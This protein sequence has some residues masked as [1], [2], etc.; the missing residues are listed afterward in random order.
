MTLFVSPKSSTLCPTLSPLLLLFYLSLSL[1]RVFAPAPGDRDL[2]SL[3]LHSL[4][5]SILPLLRAAVL[6]SKPSYPLSHV[7]AFSLDAIC[8]GYTI[9]PGSPSAREM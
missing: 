3:E 6:C 2:S 8:H 9:G 4:D 1:S 7:S 5:R